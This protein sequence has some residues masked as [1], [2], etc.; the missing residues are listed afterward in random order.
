MLAIKNWEVIK[1]KDIVTLP[2]YKYGKSGR[3]TMTN[4]L[5][6]IPNS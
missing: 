1:K 3:Q 6:Q 5:V 4:N 2:F